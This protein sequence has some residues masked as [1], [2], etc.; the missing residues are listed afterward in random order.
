MRGPLRRPLCLFLI[1]CGLCAVFFGLRLHDWGRERAETVAVLRDDLGSPRKSSLL[2]KLGLPASPSPS[3]ASGLVEDA[4]KDLLALPPMPMRTVA[5]RI[6]EKG[7]F[8]PDTGLRANSQERGRRW[9]RPAGVAVRQDGREILAAPCG[10]RLQGNRGTRDM[11]HSFRLYFRNSYGRRDV[12]GEA[13]LDGSHMD[14]RKVLTRTEKNLTPGFVTML[15]F[16]V[17]RRIGAATPDYAPIR[18]FR[19]G[20]DL[21][22]GLASEHVNRRHWERKVGHK[23]F[24]FYVLE[25]ENSVL[26]TA[27][28]RALRLR[29][30]P[31]FKPWGHDYVGSVLDLDDFMK[32]MTAFAFLQW[33]DWNQGA[34]IRDR[35]ESDP[36][37]KNIL[38]DPD[39][40]FAGL[41]PDGI[42]ANRSGWKNFR[43]ARGMRAAVFKGMW[44]SDGRFRDEMLRCLTW[45]VNQRLTRQWIV[46]RVGH[47]ARLERESGLDC[48]DEDTALAYLLDR[49]QAL[50]A[51]TVTELG[52]P[53]L[54]KC[55][56]Q[57]PEPVLIDG[58]PWSG[59]YEGMYF[60]GQKITAA[61]REGKTFSHWEVDGRNV[62]GPRLELVLESDTRIRA[63]FLPQAG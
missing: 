41:R 3:L 58:E 17:A 34:L 57:S 26:D 11:L 37:W 53:H 31:F 36:R 35:S 44:D 40:A 28:Y 49:R 20:E 50:L 56:V 60:R 25:A 30:E 33:Q 63:V 46:E 18:L 2:K 7:L 27:R 24:D 32:A 12:P 42:P 39:L 19:N 21:G 6:D 62:A 10:A 16:D 22:L 4:R 38:W 29:L 8:D 55:R 45:S 61:P 47:Y 9:E 5:V 1:I 43:D 54:V 13:F 52:A 48:F 14:L 15:A 23:D 59:E 51:E